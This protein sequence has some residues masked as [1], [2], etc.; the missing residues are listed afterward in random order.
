M[1]LA[2]QTCWHESQLVQ[3]Q[4][5]DIQCTFCA[6]VTAVAE[7][8]ERAVRSQRCPSKS[9]EVYQGDKSHALQGCA[10]AELHLLQSGKTSLLQY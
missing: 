2:G 5:V 10:R 7:P 8:E 4:P 6:A 9:P 1:L 3:R